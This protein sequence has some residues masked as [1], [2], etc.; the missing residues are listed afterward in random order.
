MGVIVV[1]CGWGIS[2]R[3]CWCLWGV[4]V[5]CVCLREVLVVAA[6]HPLWFEGGG[7]GHSLGWEW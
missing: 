6:H 4:V 7:G 5:I 1:I 3:D 2:V